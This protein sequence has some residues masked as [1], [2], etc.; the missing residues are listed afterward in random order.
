MTKC[1]G[2]C[3]LAG[4]VDS[5]RTEVKEQKKV[6]ASISA[7]RDRHNTHIAQLEHQLAEKG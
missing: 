4:E 5:R 6:I 3:I 1:V 2:V 7:A